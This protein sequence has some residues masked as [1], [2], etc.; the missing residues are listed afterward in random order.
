M[1]TTY[2]WGQDFFH[3]KQKNIDMVFDDFSAICSGNSLDLCSVND[4]FDG[5]LFFRFNRYMIET[6][7]TL[8]DKK[9]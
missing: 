5:D 6:W 8:K 1:L 4:D 3:P 7:Q 2:Q 9:K